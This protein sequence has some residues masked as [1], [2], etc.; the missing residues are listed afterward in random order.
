M[1][2]SGPSELRSEGLSQGMKAGGSRKAY[3]AVMSGFPGEA[4]SEYGLPSIRWTPGVLSPRSSNIT[5][6]PPVPLGAHC[7]SPF[8][9]ASVKQWPR[10]ESRIAPWARPD[11][12][13]CLSVPIPGPEGSGVGMKPLI[14]PIYQPHRPIF[15]YVLVDRCRSLSSYMLSRGNNFHD[16]TIN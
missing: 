16:S 12:A 13:P 14:V 8:I 9:S 2:T 11:T 1:T 3:E 10:A 15:P 5:H 4:C 6:R 7:K